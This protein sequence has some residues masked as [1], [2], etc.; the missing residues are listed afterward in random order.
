MSH[1]VNH[2]PRWAPA[3]LRIDAD[4]N[5]APGFRCVYPLENDNGLC[6]AN[7]FSLDDLPVDNHHACVVD[8]D[9]EM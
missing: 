3:D 7:T 4:G 5:T 6:G 8:D 1:V 9:E 2:I